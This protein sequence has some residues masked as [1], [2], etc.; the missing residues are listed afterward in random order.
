MNITDFFNNVENNY[1]LKNNLGKISRFWINN[2]DL[3]FDSSNSVSNIIKENL[4]I[5]NEKLDYSISSDSTLS[6]EKIIYFD[7]IIKHL[8]IEDNY[9]MKKNYDFALNQSLH[10]IKMKLDLNFSH[11]ARFLYLL[12]LRHSTNIDHIFFSIKR[13]YQYID[14]FNEIPHY[15]IKFLK[16][17]YKKIW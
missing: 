17:N 14:E 8:N 9:E 10:G 6:L 12:P 2:N 3:W 1:N 5:F 13:L 11:E 16:F 15:Y 4:L 7:Q